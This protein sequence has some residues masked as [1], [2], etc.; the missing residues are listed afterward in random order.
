M[1]RDRASYPGEAVVEASVLLVG[2]GA[3][4]GVTAAKMTGRV[5]HVAV[6]DANQEY[7]KRMRDPGLLIDELGDERRVKLDAYTEP[8]RSAVPSTSP[9]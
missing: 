5:R 9:S 6:L 7:V 3:I 4:G 8:P 1:D 2:A